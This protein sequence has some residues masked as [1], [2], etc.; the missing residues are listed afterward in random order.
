MRASYKNMKKIIVLLFTALSVARLSAQNP[1]LP[2]YAFIPDGEPHVFTTGGEE[3]L[4]I[5]GSRDEVVTDYCGYG[6]DVWSAPVSD[7]TKWT[8]H[9]EAFNVRQILDIGFGKVPNQR[10]F[11]PDCVYNP[12]TKKYYLYVFLAKGYKLDGVQGPKK[13]SVKF[14]SAFGDLGPNCFVASSDFPYGPFTDPVVCDWPSSNSNRT[15]DPSVLVSGQPDGSVRVW[16]YWG[17]NSCDRWAEL[18]PN[19]MHTVIN[20]QTRKPDNNAVYKT[21]NNPALNDY[22]SVF[23]ASSIK[24]VSKDKFVFIFSPNRK[25]SELTYCYG[26]SPE[27]PWAFGGAIVGNNNNWKGGNN[28]GSIVKVKD[29]WYVVYHRPSPNSYNRQ[30][31]IE[32]ID[33]RVENGKVVIPQVE[34]TSQGIWKNG[35]P[36]KKTYWA[37]I[38]CHIEGKAKVDGTRRVKD[39]YNPVVVDSG[40][41]VLGY[42]YVDFGK[43]KLKNLVF[44][45]QARCDGPFTLQMD[46]A[47]KGS[48][49]RIT[50]GSGKMVPTGNGADGPMDFSLPVTKLDNIAM[51]EKTGG[52]KGTMALFLTVRP[53]AGKVEIRQIGFQ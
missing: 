15:F 35:L 34:M 48:K 18:D 2:P 50:I 16:A 39:G 27:G 32:P 36:Y 51:L 33:L 30:A 1:F 26:D 19:D 37:G 53:K 38:V 45:M 7:L 29:Q 28:H 46:V 43:E 24:Q 40:G 17:A 31:M 44:S 22:R 42:K 12:I 9:G 3:R 25:V 14:A 11:A 52:L 41:A 10:L 20:A 8:C 13:D 6:H 5:Y 4:F 21:L 47:P 49:D 23:E